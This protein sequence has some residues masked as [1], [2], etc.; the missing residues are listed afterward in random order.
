MPPY[1]EPRYYNKVPSTF[2]V[3]RKA[4]RY[5]GTVRYVNQ[6][7]E[8]NSDSELKQNQYLFLRVLIVISPDIS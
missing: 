3:W 4:E 5:F 7:R 6:V 8:F 2:A 1:R